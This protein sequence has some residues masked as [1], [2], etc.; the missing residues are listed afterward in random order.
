MT[1]NGGYLMSKEILCSFLMPTRGNPELTLKS[2]KSIVTHSSN[3]IPYE[4]LIAIDSDD[5]ENLEIVS[6]INE[7]F[8]N[9]QCGTVKVIITERYF[10]YGLHKYYNL[11]ANISKGKLL[12]LWNNDCVMLDSHIHQEGINQN[13]TFSNWDLNLKQDYENLEPYV[14][15]LYPTEVYMEGS[16]RGGPPHLSNCG[17]PI[18]R[19]NIYDLLPQMSMSPLND[20]YLTNICNFKI[21]NNPTI[22]ISRVMIGHSSPFEGRGPQQETFKKASDIHYSEKVQEHTLQ[23]REVVGKYL[24][25]K[26]DSIFPS[27]LPYWDKY[28]ELKENPTHYGIPEDHIN[29]LKKLRD[30]GFNPSVI[31]D[32][33]SAVGHWREVALEIWPNAEIFMFEA[34][35]DL[36]EFYEYYGWNNYHIGLLSDKDDKST[37]YYYNEEFIGG[38]SYY[39]ENTDT[40]SEEKFRVLKSEKLETVIQRKGWPMPDLIKLDVQGAEIDILNGSGEILKY[41]EY[42]IVE[43]QHL[44]FNEGALLAEESIGIIE[45]LGY[46]LSEEKFSAAIDM[47]IDADYL[48]VNKDYIGENRR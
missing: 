32:I 28:V 15:L 1:F 13:H 30:G 20:A 17:F 40:Y 36:K 27:E 14:A 35:E 3:T 10:Y 5:K 47:E 4:V 48:F 33:G 12:F 31:Y 22:K 46:E 39:K 43:L 29:Q 41:P 42:I 38:N 6:Q 7:L 18:L 2:L 8:N 19:R 16:A 44:N 37:N 9:I 25:D 45:K 34:N 26:I 24:R 23:D 11:L 21:N